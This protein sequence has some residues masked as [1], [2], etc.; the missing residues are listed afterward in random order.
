[1]S[2]ANIPQPLVDV[3]QRMEQFM[4]SRGI[5]C[6]IVGGL[7]RD[8]WLGRSMPSLNVDLAVPS[9][10]LE[11]ARDLALH[12]G[13]A[14]VPLDEAFGT[15]RVVLALPTERVELDLSDFRGPTLEED[16]RQRD[17][18]VNA[19]AIAL[20]DWLRD[21]SRPHPLA[22]PL[23]GAQALAQQR[24]IPCFSGTFDD[25][26]L[27]ILRAF[28]FVA[29]LGFSLDPQAAPL[30]TN[31]A[32]K[33]SAIS[34]ERIRD[35]L[36]MIFATD[37][38]HHAMGAL[39]ACGVL[40]VLMPELMAGRNVSQGGFHHLHVLDHE[41][42]TVAQGD[43]FLADFAE[44][45]EPLRAPLAEYC[46]AEPVE[47]R[48]RKS[49]IKFAGLLH[50]IGKPARRT[51]EP[52]GE[53]WFIGHEHAGAK[54]VPPMLE[55]LRFA[56]RES[57]M[58][59]QLVRHHL[60]PGFLS[61]ETQLTRRAVYRFYKD[62]GEDGPACLLL[63]WADRMATRGPKSRLDQLDAQ[64]RFVEEMLQAYF[65][66]AEEVVKPTRIMDGRRLMQEFRLTPGPLIGELLEAIEEAQAEGRIRTADDALALAR[67]LIS[68]RQAEPGNS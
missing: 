46:A 20:G 62:L 41:I 18:T 36:V 57:E 59:T 1:M 31:A 63:W 39:D 7:L 13:G 38:A 32:P 24:L 60:R 50:D 40:E 52:D 67:A 37:R 9:R 33:L 17:F 19:M 8:Q 16:L 49:L 12:L 61:R 3:L 51:V 26:P 55:R 11:L 64:R 21:P 10:A 23:H 2:A 42:E 54:I 29:Q 28:R 6:Y 48:P 44:F 22:D 53:V 68:R 25:D 45:A 14:Y 47:K 56:N 35:E 65:F 5:A 27:R 4:R 34:G 15:A 43:R 66:Q 30:I 58:I